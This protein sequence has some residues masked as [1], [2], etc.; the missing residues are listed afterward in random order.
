[1]TTKY[2]IKTYTYDI[3]NY[4][5]HYLGAMLAPVTLKLF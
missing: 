4:V 1:M 5:Q 2:T 3:V